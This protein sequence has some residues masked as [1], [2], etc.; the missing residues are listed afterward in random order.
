M[1]ER[2]AVY[3]PDEI[4][5]ARVLVT[6]KTYPQPSGKYGEL[7]CTA[8]LLDGEKWVRIYPVP[9]NWLRVESRIPKYSWIRLDLRRR[10]KDFRPESYSPLRGI[11]EVFVSDGRLSTS[12]AWAARR[13]I[14][15][16]EVFESMSQLIA[17]AKRRPPKSIAT[18][19]PREVVDLVIESATTEWREEWLAQNLQGD[20]YSVAD[21]GTVRRRRLIPKLPYT[22]SLKLLSLG[23][24]RPRTMQVQDWEIGA[25]FWK[26]VRQTG[27]DRDSANRMVRDKY[28]TDLCSKRD[29]LLFLGTTI[30]NHWPSP[31]PFLVIGLF[32]P[33]RNCQMRLL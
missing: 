12:D 7:V 16:R 31:N 10:T 28:L 19:R 23:D 26:C 18:L 2:K 27:G 15:E 8:G 22:Y 29:L 24:E 17:L 13:E 30:A 9:L 21:D 3:L 4:E 32:Y 14:V 20:M 25:L 33:P 5:D 6:V 11:E 1:F